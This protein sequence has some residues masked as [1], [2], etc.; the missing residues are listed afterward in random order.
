M[1]MTISMTTRVTTTDT[2]RR[3]MARRT[4]PTTRARARAHTPHTATTAA[5]H[6]NHPSPR[7]ERPARPASPLAKHGTQPAQATPP[8]V[9]RSATSSASLAS[10]GLDPRAHSPA[11]AH[12]D[13][14][15]GSGGTGPHAPTPALMRLTTSDT[16]PPL[17]PFDTYASARAPPPSPSMA[18][19]RQHTTPPQ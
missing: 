12:G 8:S 1:M 15:G 16:Q 11:H 13:N 5:P 9:T 4:P 7:A 10:L 6:N 19:Q 3:A 18:R 17:G 2:C 14:A